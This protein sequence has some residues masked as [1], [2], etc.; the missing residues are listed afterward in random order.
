MPKRTSGDQAVYAGPDSEPL[1]PRLPVEVDC[2]LKHNPP[3]R[4]LHHRQCVHRLLRNPERPLVT[5]SL[6]DLL[7]HRKTRHGLI[8]IQVRFNGTPGR[9]AEHFDPD[10]SINEQH[11]LHPCAIVV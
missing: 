4:R 3:E 7:N 1:A 11:R 2:I 10:R 6:Q 8:Q 9:L 5:E